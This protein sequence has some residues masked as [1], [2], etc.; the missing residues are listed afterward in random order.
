MGLFPSSFCNSYILLAIDY[1]SKWVEAK[2]TITDNVKAIVSFIKT[3]IFIR[4]GVPRVMINDWGMHFCNWVTE[5]LFKKYH[6][7][8]HTSTAYHP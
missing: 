3:H 1:L 5:A 8:H 6:V 7:T 4:F 2:A